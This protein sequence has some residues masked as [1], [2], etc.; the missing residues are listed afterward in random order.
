MSCRNI[1]TIGDELLRKKSRPVEEINERILEL[2]DDMAET[3]YQSGGV[4]LAAPQVGVL[5]RIAVIDV[6][7]EFGDG[8]LELINPEIIAASGEQTD[9]EGCL[10]VPEYIG[11]VTR[12]LTVTVRAQN[13][14]SETYEK[15]VSGFFARAVCHELDHLDGVLFV[16]HAVEIQKREE[17]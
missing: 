14:N 10:S 17:E 11:T 8:L 2:L 9:A 12:P 1:R 3:M 7:K 6:G 15:T 5:R 4:G 13:R 16:D